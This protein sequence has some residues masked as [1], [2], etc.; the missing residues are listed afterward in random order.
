MQGRGRQRGVPHDLRVVM[1][2]DVDKAGRHN[3]PIAFN[4]LVGKVSGRDIQDDAAVH[5]ADILLASGSS[6]AINN[7]GVTN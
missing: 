7:Q 6:G 4:N 3:Q 2:V 5:N 1:G